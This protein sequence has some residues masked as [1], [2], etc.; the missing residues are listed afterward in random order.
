MYRVEDEI[1]EFSSPSRY[2]QGAGLIGKL[3]GYTARFG[4]KVFALIDAYF[5]DALSEEL[6]R[7]YESEGMEF[8]AESFSAEVTV[9]RI[10]L[11]AESL[12]EFA[13]DAVLGIGGGK[14]IDTA[15][16][17]AALLKSATVIVPTTASTD[18]PTIALSTLY[19]DEGLPAGAR[20]YQT[21]PDIVLVDSRVIADAP[22][23]FLVSGMGDALAT[24]F[25]ARACKANDSKNYAGYRGTVLANSIAETCYKTLLENGKKALHAARRH[26]IT[27]ALEDIIETNVLLSGLG[28]ENTGVAGAHSIDR[29]IARQPESKHTLHG[30]RVGFGTLCQLVVENAPKDLLAEALEFCASVGLPITLKDLRIENT[31][32]KISD[33]AERSMDTFWDREPLYITEEKVAAAI[34]AVDEMGIEYRRIHNIPAALSAGE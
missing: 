12:K 22:V 9:E 21:N 23:R 33:I 29:A 19:T 3:P 8:R 16:G 31:K 17:A 4:D 34:A 1:R 2:Y 11:V 7:L 14:T 28:V 32:K 13:P 27:E 26:V 30:E 25:E 10:A 15:K 24:V 18:A 6:K 20:K 5:Y